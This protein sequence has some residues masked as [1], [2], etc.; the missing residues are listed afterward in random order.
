MRPA[1]EK[2]LNYLE[3]VEFSSPE[4]SVYSNI[5][6]NDVMDGKPAEVTISRWLRDKLALQVMKPVYWQKTIENMI[7]GGVEL[8][9]EF[10]PGRALNGFL[11]KIS[12]ATPIFSVEGADS[13]REAL[14][15]ARD[16]KG[17]N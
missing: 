5:T 1:A 17:V 6:G 11:K 8:F 4:V 9:L 2:L 15:G 12:P 10:G 3:N 16:L 13:L 14:E 7:A